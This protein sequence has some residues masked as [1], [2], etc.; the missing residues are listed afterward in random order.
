MTMIRPI[1]I[2]LTLAMVLVSSYATPGAQ[3]PSA[4]AGGAAQQ[5]GGG[6][7]GRGGGLPGAT[8]EQTQA[9]ADMNAALAVL[10]TA[11]TTARM[12]LATVTFAEVRN[13]A[14]IAAA[15]EKVRGAELALA[16]GRAT[17][18]AKLQAGSSKLNAEQVAA[19]VA[20]GG[21]PGAGRGAGGRAGGAPGG[22]AQGGGAPARG[23]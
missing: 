4:P 5:G 15:V 3:T 13:P 1:G 17:E 12:E 14:A 6:R 23:N 10:N 11:V 9:V 7:G 8:P 21:N 18:F 2:L 16:L 19:L 20:A 22:G